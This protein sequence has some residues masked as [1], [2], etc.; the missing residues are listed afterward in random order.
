MTWKI[1]SRPAPPRAAQPLVSFINF[2]LADGGAQEGCV[3]RV[4]ELLR[5]RP[6]VNVRRLIAKLST[7]KIVFTLSSSGYC[8]IHWLLTHSFS[9]YVFSGALVFGAVAAMVVA[10]LSNS[11]RGRSEAAGGVSCLVPPVND[12]P[13]DP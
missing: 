4:S 3:M 9:T 7:F 8:A 1:L 11:H 13:E 6:M 10:W 12:F 5:Q 2:A